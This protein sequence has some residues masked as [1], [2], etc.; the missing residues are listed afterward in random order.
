MVFFFVATLPCDYA[1]CNVRKPNSTCQP[2]ADLNSKAYECKCD[3]G[4]YGKDGKCI[5]MLLANS[6]IYK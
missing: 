1:D 5:G 6:L 4:F 2:T 3:D